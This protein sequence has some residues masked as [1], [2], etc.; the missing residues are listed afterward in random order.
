MTLTEMSIFF[1]TELSGEIKKMG[2]IQQAH[3][4][5]QVISKM[6]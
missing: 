1:W 6:M 4:P 5:Y 3:L 2:N